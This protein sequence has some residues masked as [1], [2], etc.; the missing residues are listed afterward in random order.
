[1]FKQNTHIFKKIKSDKERMRERQ[2]QHP[3]LER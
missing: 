2:N 1:M 3:K